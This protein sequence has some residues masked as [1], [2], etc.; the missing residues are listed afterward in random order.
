MRRWKREP[1]SHSIS[2]GERC[3]SRGRVG[4]LPARRRERR[5]GIAQ[6]D[7]GTEIYAAISAR[8]HDGTDARR[9]IV[10]QLEQRRKEVRLLDD[11]AWQS[12]LDEQSQLASTI[13]QKGAERGQR[14]ER[15]D[16]FQARHCR[17]QRPRTG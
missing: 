2:S 12:L 13:A 9:R 7:T 6:E 10:E 3:S 1:I 4:R 14:S 5:R 11:E 15:L 16:P 8:V 17:P